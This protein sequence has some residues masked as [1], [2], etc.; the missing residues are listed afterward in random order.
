MAR[1]FERARHGAA[2]L[3]AALAV[4]GCSDAPAPAEGAAAVAA[5]PEGSAA[6]TD[7]SGFPLPEGPE[8][9]VAD[10]DGWELIVHDSNLGLCV[11]LRLPDQDEVAC[12][13]EVPERHAVGYITQAGPGG[14][15]LIAG[16]VAPEATTVTVAAGDERVELHP[17][18]VEAGEEPLSVFVGA[19]PGDA[20][21]AAVTARDAEGFELERRGPA[22]PPA[23]DR[24]E[25]GADLN[26]QDPP[27]VDTATDGPAE[28]RG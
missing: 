20:P 21:V 4:A 22:E 8:V 25:T 9:A 10:G 5:T 17:Q 11:V 26:A 1:R 12:G 2:A 18:P 14:V 27:P 23:P 13:F 6:P 3:V 24:H 15:Q 19:L 16:V 28:S 7:A